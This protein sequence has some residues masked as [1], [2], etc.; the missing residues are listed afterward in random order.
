MT[1]TYPIMNKINYQHFN[2]L[3]HRDSITRY[4]IIIANSENQEMA[5]NKICNFVLFADNTVPYYIIIYI[6]YIRICIRH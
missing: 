3:L 1:R 4:N 6:L 2:Y 5:P